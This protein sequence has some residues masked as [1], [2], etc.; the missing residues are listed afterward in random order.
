MTPRIN[1]AE[2]TKL[3]ASTTRRVAGLTTAMASPTV[4]GTTISTAVAPPKTAVLATAIRSRPTSTGNAPKFAPSNNVDR[5]GT[6]NATT[7]TCG[8][9]RTPITCATGIEPI[10]TA[11][12]TSAKTIT[13]CRSHRSARAPKSRPKTT[14]GTASSA[15]TSAVR[16]G[17]PLSR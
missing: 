6:T 7:I 16:K 14:Y 8:T 17:E 12:E 10:T 1:K 3:S 2:A 15:D 11:A 4:P 9:V 13:R 5:D